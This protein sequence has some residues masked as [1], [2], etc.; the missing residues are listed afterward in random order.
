M[1]T[2]CV[3][4]CECARIPGGRRSCQ[5][6]VIDKPCEHQ[7]SSGG[8]GSVGNNYLCIYARIKAGMKAADKQQSNI[9]MYS[10]RRGGMMSVCATQ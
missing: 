4:V 3:C 5:L 2:M 10:L 9:V 8:R 1:S 6:A 7:V